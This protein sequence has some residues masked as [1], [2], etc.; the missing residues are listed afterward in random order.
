[1]KRK[2]FVLV[3]ASCLLMSS[4]AAL[5]DPSRIQAQKDYE[6]ALKL[7]P[8]PENGKNVYKLCAVCHGP[9]GWGSEDGY[10]PQIAGQLRTVLI[11]QLAD[12]RDRNRDN[13]TM[14]PFT[15]PRMLGGVQEIADVAAYVA[16]LPM[17]PNNGVGPGFDLER[18]RRI[19]KK[20]CAECHGEQ[21]EGDVEDHI[22]QI[23]GQHFRYLVRQFEWIRNGRRR[24]AD[25]KM[26]KQ[27]RRFTHGDVRAVMDY[28]SRLGPP[29]EKR[30]EPGWT[31]SDFP[32][33]IR[34]GHFG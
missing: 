23:R 3:I 16:D 25:E 18:G 24:N 4:G 11:K 26:V 14:F 32:N 28:V 31:N 15:Q 29:S 17:A 30:A 10:Y 13:P 20:E 2:K 1:M 27:V 19:Y 33:F 5:S 9:E 6:A 21:G 7:T 34:R 12:I 22:P 8:N